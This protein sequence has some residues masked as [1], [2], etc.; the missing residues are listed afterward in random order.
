MIRDSF[1]SSNLHIL[2]KRNSS[3]DIMRMYVR[4]PSLCIE[5]RSISSRDVLK[6]LL[7][8]HNDIHVVIFDSWAYNVPNFESKILDYSSIGPKLENSCD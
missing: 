1:S 2:H 3:S 4:N 5:M 6:L 7:L 8:V